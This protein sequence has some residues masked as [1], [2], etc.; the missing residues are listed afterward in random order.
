MSPQP[1]HPCPCS[2]LYSQLLQEAQV[3]ERAG[4]QLADVVHAQVS[5]RKQRQRFLISGLH[6]MN[7]SAMLWVPSVLSGRV[8]SLCKQHF[9]INS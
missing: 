7:L 5:G 9:S 8:R 1:Q 4:L 3:P 2:A 6:R